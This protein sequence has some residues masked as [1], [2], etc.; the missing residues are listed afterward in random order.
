V[1]YPIGRNIKGL[2]TER[3]AML[4]GYRKTA[5]GFSIYKPFLDILMYFK[6]KKIVREK[7]IDMVYAFLHEGALIG[8]LIRK[9]QELHHGFD[10]QG[11]LTGELEAHNTIKSK[12]LIKKLIWKLET[13]ITNKADEIVTSTQ[14]LKEFLEANFN[15]QK[16]SV[17]KDLPDT[18]LFNPN[19]KQANISL[20]SDKKIVVYLGGMQPYKGTNALINAIPHTSQKYH[21]L[22]MGYPIEQAQT[23]ARDMGVDHRITFTGKIPYEQA[24]SYLKCGDIAISPKTLE[25]GEA[26]AKIYNYIAMG[27]PIVCFKMEETI[28]LQKAHPD[29]NF[30]MSEEGSENLAKTIERAG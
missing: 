4:P 11:S 20:P 28:E 25:S 2:K 9:P 13:Y 6:C 15:P 19:V 10:T 5:P 7:N 21:F 24:P 16:V 29:A 18:G 22:L 14:G 3:V 8:Q 27:L 23:L 30:F 12:G 1:T 26:N 17:I